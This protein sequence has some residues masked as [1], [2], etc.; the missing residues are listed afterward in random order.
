MGFN[1]VFKGLNTSFLEKLLMQLKLYCMFMK[2][3][4][5]INV[6][7]RKMSSQG[8]ENSNSYWN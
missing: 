5:N 3:R 4:S 2:G 7:S 6:R 8:N 1:S